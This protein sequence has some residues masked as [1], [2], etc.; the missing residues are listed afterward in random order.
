MFKKATLVLS[1]FAVVALGKH[2][3]QRKY[4]EDSIVEALVKSSPA[5]ENAADYLAGFASGFLNSDIGDYSRCYPISSG[6][7]TML[8]QS[9]LSF[10]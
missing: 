10:H 9:T 2:T 5:A 7:I 4:T 6:S 3:H 8:T 1:I